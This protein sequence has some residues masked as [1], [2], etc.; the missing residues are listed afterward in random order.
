MVE[1]SRRLGQRRSTAPT[2]T[3]TVDAQTKLEK[4]G[5][6]LTEVK[7]GRLWEDEENTSAENKMI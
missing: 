5:G 2:R 7:G 4:S 1:A 6:W 3:N